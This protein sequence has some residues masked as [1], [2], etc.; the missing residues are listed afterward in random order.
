MKKTH[1]SR[2]QMNDMIETRKRM[3]ERALAAAELKQVSGGLAGGTCS[4][5]ADC[6]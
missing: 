4:D 1:N 2:I 6:D 5:T 3:G